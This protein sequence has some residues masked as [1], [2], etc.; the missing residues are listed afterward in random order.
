MIERSKVPISLAILIVS[1]LSNPMSG[2]YT[3]MEDMSSRTYKLSSVCDATWAS[4]FPVTIPLL[5]L[6]MQF[7]L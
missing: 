7:F 3:G 1:S 4:D 6:P 2:R 5:Q